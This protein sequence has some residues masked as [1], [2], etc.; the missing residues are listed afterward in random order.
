MLLPVSVLHSFFM[1]EQ[2]SIMWVDHV[3]FSVAVLFLTWVSPVLSCSIPVHTIFDSCPEGDGIRA[4]AITRDAKYLA[5]I[6]D[7]EIQVQ[8]LSRQL[9]RLARPSQVSPQAALLR[10]CGVCGSL[11]G[12]G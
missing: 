10:P 6:S 2:L 3:C 11:G 1:A 7:A 5:T 4:I 8:G 9:Q 12:G